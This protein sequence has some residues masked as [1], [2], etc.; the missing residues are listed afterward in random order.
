MNNQFGPE[1]LDTVK[2]EEL[3][4]PPGLPTC[5]PLGGDQVIDAVTAD[6]TGDGEVNGADIDFIEARFGKRVGEEGYLD[7][8]DLASDDPALPAGA[9]DG[10][11]NQADVNAVQQHCGA[12]GVQTSPTTLAGL[13]QDAEGNPLEDV[14]VQVGINTVIGQTDALGA[15]DLNIPAD[16]TG[17]TEITIDGST[18]I[19]PT[20]GGSGEYPV[21]PHK[22]IFINPGK[23][24]TFRIIALPE[25]D[26]DG[27]Q[28]LD[29]SNSTAA[30]ANARTLTQEA[31]VDNTNAQAKLTVPSGCTAT[32]PNGQPT[33]LSLTKLDPSKLPVA[34]PPGQNSS[35]YVT[36][37]PGGTMIDCPPGVNIL[38]EFENVD[39]FRRRDKPTLN[40]V[41]NGAFAPLASCTVV[42][43]DTDRQENDPDDTIRCEVA[44]PFE[45][46]WYGASV[47]GSPC[48]LTTVT[49][50]VVCD[51]TPVPLASVVLPGQ[52]A[53]TSDNVPDD[54]QHGVFGFLNVPAGPNGPACLSNPFT[55]QVTASQG[56]DVGISAPVVSVPGGITD[57][58]DVDICAGRGGTGEVGDMLLVGIF[59]GAISG[60]PTE[61][62]FVEIDYAAPIPGGFSS[63]LDLTIEFDLD[64]DSSTGDSSLII[65]P[66]DATELGVDARLVCLSSL[67][68][69]TVFDGDGFPVGDPVDT[70]VGFRVISG[71]TD[72]SK[73]SIDIPLDELFATVGEGS[74]DIDMAIQS[75]I[76]DDGVSDVFPNGGSTTFTLPFGDEIADPAGDIFSLGVL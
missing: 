27:A 41:V 34:Q 11:I 5:Q 39:L 71:E 63:S 57:V 61:R 68:E 58:G 36:F 9:P 47:T 18:A 62:V 10:V 42:D 66:F 26:L 43:T 13:V 38:A 44:T 51:G 46:A 20:S 3:C 70:G 76:R 65:S 25:R 21:I 19:D 28:A 64:Q 35:L 52:P 73:P 74:G 75:V 2:E 6:L 53:C 45:F 40:G 24:N 8:L 23:D 69:L 15:Y 1:L 56:G 48:P 33:T 31:I 22:P 37:Q 67:C 12:T 4:V 54:P 29:N 17:E 7:G 16:D 14:T 32:F 30:G 55:Q 49:G 72:F 50:R 59:E 60:D